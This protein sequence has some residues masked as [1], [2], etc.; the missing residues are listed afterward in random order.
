MKRILDFEKKIIK[1]FK[2]NYITI[3]LLIITLLVLGIRYYELDFESGDFT[4]FLSPW[5]DYLKNNG[6][7]KALSNYP[8]DYNAPYVTIIALLTYLP[9]KKLYLIKT[10]SVI[11]DFTLALS[12]AYLVGYIV[13]KNKKEYSLLTYSSIL[14]LPTVFMNSA[15]WSQCDA[16]YATFIIL[17]LLYLLKEKYIKSFIL[18]GV[19]FA[20]KLQ[21]MFVL[22]I[23]IVIYISKNKFSILYF[24]IIPLVNF[25]LCIPAMLFGKPIKDILTVYFNQTQT[26]KNDLS[27]NFPNIYTI[28]QG[29]PTVFYRVG[30][31]LTIAACVLMLGF[32]IYKK[33]KWNNE[34]IL[35]LALWF[36]VITTFLL[37][38]MHERYMYVGEV[39][40]IICYIAYKKNLSLTAF[41]LTASTITYSSFLFNEYNMNMQ[42]LTLAYLAVIILFTKNTLKLL[43]E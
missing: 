7:L 28:I 16:G 27:L 41:I 25:I 32:V 2:D 5:F 3:G 24:L 21:F 18:L 10:V 26:Y 12:A 15:L 19:A 17:S 31:L 37:P 11:F 4:R 33:V 20:L 29:T 35:N 30:F 40:S 8:G 39:L 13:P 14:L 42:Y 6:G 1:F 36:I 38:G 22:P 34:K 43:S 23:F 9:I